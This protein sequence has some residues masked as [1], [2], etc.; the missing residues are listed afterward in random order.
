MRRRREKKAA[1][2]LNLLIESITKNMNTSFEIDYRSGG[3]FYGIFEGEN[4]VGE[5]EEDLR[6]T[7]GTSEREFS[8]G[9]EHYFVGAPHNHWSH[10][11]TR[12]RLKRWLKRVMSM[13]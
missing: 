13:G 3:S 10:P 7:H 8:V 6:I 1:R 11:S 12:K 2:R 4:L 5:Y 9:Y